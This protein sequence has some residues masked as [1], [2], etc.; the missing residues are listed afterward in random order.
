MHGN[1][2]VTLSILLEE[3]SNG[4]TVRQMEKSRSGGEFP[5]V[6]IEADVAEFEEFR[7]AFTGDRGVFAGAHGEKESAND[8]LA[9]GPIERSVGGRGDVDGADHSWRD[10][11]LRGWTRVRVFETLQLASQKVVEASSVV[12]DGRWQFVCP[13]GRCQSVEGGPDGT[14]LYSISSGTGEGL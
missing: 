1:C 9:N 7:T 14:F 2:F 4:D 6:F 11:L 5:V 10:G 3:E 13:I 12:V 8:E